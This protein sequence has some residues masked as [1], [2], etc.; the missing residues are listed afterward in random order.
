MGLFSRFVSGPCA[1]LPLSVRAVPNV[2][3]MSSPESTLQS[4]RASII[5]APVFSRPI[6][7]PAT[8][9]QGASLVAYSNT[10]LFINGKWRPSQSGRTIAVLNPAT[11]ETIGTVAHADR[12]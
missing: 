7:H 4:A 11:E 8:I 12:V 6:R 5:K 3:M 10:Q 1:T 2:G 9:K